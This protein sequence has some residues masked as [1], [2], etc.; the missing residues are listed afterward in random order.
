V[1]LAITGS[2]FPDCAVHCLLLLPGVHSRKVLFRPSI[3]SL[4]LSLLTQV[5]CIAVEPGYYPPNFNR[6]FFDGKSIAAA[7]ESES[8]RELHDL[9]GRRD[10]VTLQVEAADKIK[11]F[12]LTEPIPESFQ[13][14]WHTPEDLAM[15]LKD[16]SA[17]TL[18]RVWIGHSAMWQPAEKSAALTRELAPFI[19]RLGFERVL[20]LGLKPHDDGHTYMQPSNGLVRYGIFVFSDTHAAADEGVGTA[21]H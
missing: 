2:E 8:E 18:L 10:G 16:F 1:G 7:P 3:C 13:K 21:R 12:S 5:S 14:A 15:C 19:D 4:I 11:V 9:M 20:V 17:K 6:K